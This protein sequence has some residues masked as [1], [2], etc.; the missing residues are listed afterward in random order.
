VNVDVDKLIQAMVNAIAKCYAVPENYHIGFNKEC[1][2]ALIAL[3]CKH[4]DARLRYNVPQG[5]LMFNGFVV[6][7]DML[8]PMQ[9]PILR[10][11]R[12]KA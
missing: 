3:A 7:E 11:V 8:S 9:I 2:D 12:K 5:I 10:P 4:K 1:R 6:Q